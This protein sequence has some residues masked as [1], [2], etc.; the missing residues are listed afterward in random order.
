MD[1]DN[2]NTEF[3]KRM[4]YR[5]YTNLLNQLSLERSV[6]NY[7]FIFIN[8]ILIAANSWVLYTSLS[9]VSSVPNYYS[10]RLLTLV[11]PSVFLLLIEFLLNYYWFTDM[12]E[13][14]L[15]QEIRFRILMDFENKNNL[16][17]FINEEW[18]RLG[19]IASR[20]SPVFYSRFIKQMPIFFMFMHI[21]Q[22][23]SVMFIY[24]AK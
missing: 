22:C 9:F 20:K 18:N 1:D 5:D 10:F 15:V 7:F 13:S 16:D 12:R 17:G 2:E 19:N 24:F 11:Y 21:I 4:T 6:S 23:F 14:F 3:L 8:V